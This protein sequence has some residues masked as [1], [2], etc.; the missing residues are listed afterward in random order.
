MGLTTGIIG[1]IGALSG[2]FGG[3]GASN[4]QS[5]PS[6]SYMNMPGADAGAYG[7]I[8]NLSQYGNAGASTLP[9]ATN[10]FQGLYNNPYAAGAQGG[11]NYASGLGQTAALGAYGA[12]ANLTGAGIGMLPYASSIM[13]TAMDPQGALYN[14][15]LG[16]VT[17]AANAQNAASGISM[18]PYGAGVAN[19]ANSNFNIN[20][21]NN[22]LAREATGASAAGGLL[23]NAG[24]AINTGTGI[25]NTAPGQYASAAAMPYATAAGIGQG[26]NAATSSYLSNI[27]Q[28]QGIPQQQIQDYLTYMQGG[29]AQQNANTN[30]MQ[31]QI[32]Q[33]NAAYNQQMGYGTMLGSSLYGIGKGPTGGWSNPW[34]SSGWG[35][36]AQ[37]QVNY[38]TTTGSAWG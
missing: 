36:S 31:T 25:M 22:Q 26:Q 7:G 17:N 10:T 27:M 34:G 5:P 19:T 8:G 38:G 4:I 24:G 29:T 35:G 33:S 20:W 18:T 6:Y 9:Y 37:P 28:A 12:G 15:T 30:L 23:S 21:E 32:N 1:G 3:G 2:L 13:N 16:Q 11:A 14:Q